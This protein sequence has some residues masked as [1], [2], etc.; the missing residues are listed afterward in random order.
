MSATEGI[1]ASSSRVEVNPEDVWLLEKAHQD[2][3]RRPATGQSLWEAQAAALAEAGRLLPAG[4][5]VQW[6]VQVS[7]PSLI[8]GDGVVV[9]AGEIGA[10]L[11]AGQHGKPVVRRV[12][13]PWLPVEPTDTASIDVGTVRPPDLESVVSIADF[14]YQSGVNF[15]P[16]EP[17]DTPEEAVPPMVAAIDDAVAAGASAPWAPGE[18]EEMLARYA[19][20][21]D[22]PKEKP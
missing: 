4:A 7:P 3:G 20:P 18:R 2:W 16:V 12:A 8:Y 21:T 9:F 10:R 1:P 15:E 5:E 14:P 19:A 13:G 11:Y 22:T 6:G 17:T